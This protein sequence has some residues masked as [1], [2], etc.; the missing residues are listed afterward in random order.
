MLLEVFLRPVLSLRCLQYIFEFVASTNALPQFIHHLFHC[1][2]VVSLVDEFIAFV[3]QFECHHPYVCYK[4]SRLTL[5][6]VLH[7]VSLYV[8]VMP[9]HC[10]NQCFCDSPP[11][12][13]LPPDPVLV[14]YSL[15]PSCDILVGSGCNLGSRA[16][17]L[18]PISMIFDI[19]LF[20]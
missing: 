19:S 10:L 8:S 18:K 15:P 7:C 9:F 12:D 1:F 5:S 2:L 20:P 14:V 4:E 6:C 16:L 11:Y 3:P 13:M 17:W